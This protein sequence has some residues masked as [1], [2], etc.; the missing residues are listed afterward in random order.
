MSI[1]EIFTVEQA[2]DVWEQ[3]S[4]VVQG[5]EYDEYV[6]AV[7]WALEKEF[8][9]VFDQRTGV[10]ARVRQGISNPIYSF[11]S[12]V[13]FEEEEEVAEV[14]KAV[15]PKFQAPK[16]KSA[17][18][19]R[20]R[21]ESVETTGKLTA[22][23]KAAKTR[24]LKKEAEEKAKQEQDAELS[25][26]REVEEK[27]KMVISE[28]W[29]VKNGD[30]GDCHANLKRVERIESVN[31]EL[32]NSLAIRDEYANKHAKVVDELLK[33]QEVLKRDVEMYQAQIKSMQEWVGM[34]EDSVAKMSE[35]SGKFSAAKK[36]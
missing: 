16:A 19:K 10:V 3:H 25:R 33:E 28:P 34:I 2:S 24:L 15:P 18:K 26:L 22:A 4:V 9:V 35:V 36:Q 1:V 11:V 8:R 27:Y 29:L 12:E 30:C 5:K 31:K 23:E 13:E 7:Q 32:L 6:A 17:P 20:E 21:E 14:P